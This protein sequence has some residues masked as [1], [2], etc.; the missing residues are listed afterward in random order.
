MQEWKFLHSR[1]LLKFTRIERQS[2]VAIGYGKS[3]YL[4]LSVGAGLGLQ[5]Q[6]VYNTTQALQDELWVSILVNLVRQIMLICQH[7][8][9]LYIYLPNWVN[10]IGQIIW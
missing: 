6:D 10:I 7:K 8:C 5:I 1:P 2:F 3:K 4:K 9:K